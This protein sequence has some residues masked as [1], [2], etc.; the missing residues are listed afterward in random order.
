MG[1]VPHLYIPP[2]WDEP[3]Q[4]LDPARAHHLRTVLRL[5][6]GAPLSYTDGVGTVGKGRLEGATVV[7]GDEISRHAPRVRLTVAVAPPSARD[8]Q[9][10]L[11][12][13]CAELGVRRIRW[14]ATVHGAAR[15]PPGS[16]AQSW[17]DAA[18]EQSRGAWRTT[19]D[20]T[21]TGTDELA[22]TVVVADPAGTDRVPTASEVT[23]LIG[24][25]GGWAP[26]EWAGL[27]KI[28]LGDRI[29][30]VE[31]AAVV[32]AAALLRGG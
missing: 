30:R 32:G 20:D 6:D 9:R 8:R 23:L 12:E 11:V 27:P 15:R 25:E 26:G 3:G 31:T 13:K 1:H 2:P 24:P 10:F 18:L 17:A 21:T 19:V 5:A 28:S 4:V 16:K 22:G 7:R 29:L 14:L